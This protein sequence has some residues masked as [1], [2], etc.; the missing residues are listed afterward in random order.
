MWPRSGLRLGKMEKLD[1]LFRVIDSAES[2]GLDIELRRSDF[3]NC[4][5][6]LPAEASPND[7][8][9]IFGHYVA[10]KLF[11]PSPALRPRSE[12]VIDDLSASCLYQQDSHHRMTFGSMYAN[13][14]GAKCQFDSAKNFV[15]FGRPHVLSLD[16]SPRHL[17]VH[18]PVSQDPLNLSSCKGEEPSGIELEV[19]KISPAMHS[20]EVLRQPLGETNGPLGSSRSTFSL[21]HVGYGSRGSSCRPFKYCNIE[22]QR[23]PPIGWFRLHSADGVSLLIELYYR[24]SGAFGLRSTALIAQR[25]FPLRLHEINVRTAQSALPSPTPSLRDFSISITSRSPKSIFKHLGLKLSLV[26]EYR[27]RSDQCTT[28]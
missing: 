9:L 24:S 13:E 3:F 6:S 10:R 12:A 26:Q 2:K 14:V 19:R 17:G 27:G 20:Q 18:K 1:V 25:R 7:G 22:D 11:D 8:D 15:H 28:R 21:I 16:G 23:L 5:Q 4:C